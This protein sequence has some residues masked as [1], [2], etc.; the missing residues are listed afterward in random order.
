MCIIDSVACSC[1]H[2]EHIY[3]KECGTQ[4]NRCA[5]QINPSKS[6]SACQRCLATV[7]AEERK[8]I[9]ADFYDNAM[10]YLT[11]S[12]KMTDTFDRELL[13]PT[14][15]EI[16]KLMDKQKDFSLFELDLKITIEDQ[17]KRECYDPSVWF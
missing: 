3:S 12:L 1:S 10:F 6:D 2:I 16:V 15:R 8:K 13:A 5:K 14:V 9:I 7:T 17:R 11:N 4:G